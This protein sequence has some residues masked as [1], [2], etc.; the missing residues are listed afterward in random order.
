MLRR[1]CS[2]AS[3][4]PGFF[5]KIFHHTNQILR[6]K[7]QKQLSVSD[8]QLWNQ[9]YVRM[10]AERSGVFS[11]D[12]IQKTDVIVTTRIEHGACVGASSLGYFMMIPY[13][14]MRSK[15]DPLQKIARGIVYHELGHIFHRDYEEFKAWKRGHRPWEDGYLDLLYEMEY[16]QERRADVFAAECLQRDT[17]DDPGC[18][19]SMIAELKE[20]EE[21]QR[22]EAEALGKTFDA[23]REKAY[24]QALRKYHPHPSIG[25]RIDYFSL[26]ERFLRP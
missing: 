6:D 14:G 1:Y 17:L 24:C 8:I 7:P 25:S 11:R 21:M 26:C 5:Q 23:Y 16:R 20:A 9:D 18:F 4:H 15:P 13:N 12:E 2:T 10:L 22:A 19:F 3:N